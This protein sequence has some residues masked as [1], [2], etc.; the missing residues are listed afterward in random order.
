MNSLAVVPPRFEPVDYDPFQG[1]PLAVVVP[2]TDPQ[3]EIWLADQLGTE[4]SLAF[5]L[6]VSLHLRGP[7]DV[8]ALHAALQDLVDRNDSLRASVGP[9]GETFCVLEHA[10]IA[11]PCLD[12]ASMPAAERE[13]ARVARLEASVRTPFDLA[14]GPLFRAELLRLGDGE[15]LLMLSAHHIACDGWSWWVLVRELG[16]LYGTRTGAAS[17]PPGPPASFADYALAQ[18]DA[19]ADPAN[20][21]DEAYWLARF[22]DQVPVLDLPTD[23][24]RPVRRGTASARVDHVLHDAVLEELRKLGARRGRSLFAT[25]LAGFSGLLSRLTGQRDV[26]VGIPA[27]GQPVAGIETLVGHCVSTL[28]LRFDVD[29]AQSFSD[30]VDHAQA[31]LID[32]LEHQRITFGSLLAKLR[33]ERDPSRVPLV[34][35]LFNLDQ[36]LDQEGQSFPGLELAFR[37][38]PRANETF[39]LFVN[40]VQQ[41]GELHLECQYNSDLFDGATVKRWLQSYEALL[42][43]AVASDATEF[44]RLPVLDRPALE[45]LDALHDTRRPYDRERRMHEYLELQ[46]DRSPGRTAVVCGAVA[47]TYAELDARANR[48]ANLLRQHGVGRGALVGLAVDR[49]VDMLV[50][51]LGVLKSGAGYVPLDPH[52]P[53]ARL[54]YM[55]SDAGLRLLVASREHVARF[56][57]TPGTVLVLEDAM[58]ALDAMPATRPGR[59]GAA[60]RPGDVAY[61]IYTSGSTGRPKGVVVPHRAVSNFLAAML[62]EPGLDEGDRLVAV[63]TLSFD[64]AVLELLLPLSVGACVVLADRA[65]AADGHELAG[66]LSRS[67]ATVM[68]ATPSTWR[69]LLE[70]GWRGGPAFKALCG[71]EALPPDLAARLTTCCGE[72]WNL[73][74][75]TETTVWSTAARIHASPDESPPDVCIGRPIANTIVRILDPRGEPCP[76]GVPGEICIGGDGVTLG[77]LGRP[78]MTAERFVPDRLAGAGDD[79]VLYRTGDRGRWR[80]DGQ[81]EHLGRLDFQVKVR[82]YRIELGEVEASLASHPTVAGTVAT[83]REDV[84][85]DARLVAYVVPASGTAVDVDGLV[86]HLRDR[87]PDYMLPQHVVVLDAL[88]LLPN[89]KVDRGSLPMPS[90]VVAGAAT[91][92]PPASEAERRITELVAAVLGQRDVGPDDDFFAMGG[93]SLLGARLLAR[94]GDAFGI[95]VPLR[96][97]FEA[98][99]AA[100]L[101]QAVARIAEARDAAACPPTPGEIARQPD[102]SRAPLSPMQQRVWVQE[103]LHPGRATFGIASAYRLRGGLDTAALG[104]ALA[105]VVAHQPSLRTALEVEG[106]DP[107]QRVHG[108]VPVALPLEDLSDRPGDEAHAEAMRRI[109]ALSAE[110]IA[111]AAAPLF[112]TRLFRLDPETHVLFFMAHHAIWD[113]V[114]QHL[115]E[116]EMAQAYGARV[117]G[118]AVALPP[119]ERSYVDFV[120]W[121]RG[122]A[123]LPEAREQLAHWL[124]RLP[125]GIEPLQL[126][127]DLPRPLEPSGRGGSE[128]VRID[129]DT[130]AGLRRLGAAVDASL[131]M[132]LLAVYFAWLYRLTGQRDLVVG[133]PVRSHVPATMDG[134]MGFFVN[135]L[136]V[137]VQVDPGA[138]FMALI[139]RV[140]D[141]VLDCFSQ[142]DVALEALVQGLRLRRDPSRTPLYQA[143]FSFQEQQGTAA[144]WATVACEPLDLPQATASNDLAAWCVANDDGLRATLNYNADILLPSS[145][146]AMARRFEAM[147]ARVEARPDAVLGD[148][149]WLSAEDSRA[150]AAWNAT[151]A[152]VQGPASVHGMLAAQF[153]AT[154]HAEAIVLDGK[155]TSYAQLEARSRRIAAALHARGVGA[156]DLVGVCLD[157]H[158]DMVACL[159]GILAAGAGYVPLDPAY[160]ADR[161]R[162]MAEDAGLVMVVGE[163]D[164]ADPLGLPD[165]RL[166]RLDA[167]A[168]WIDGIA[169]DVRL[170]EVGPDDTAYVIY[171]SGSTGKPKGVRIPHGAVANFLAS[172]RRRPGILPSDRLLA[173]TTTSFDIAVLEI[174]L[175]LA[176]GACVVLASRED[177]FD[178]VALASLLERSGA[179]MMQGTPSVWRLLLDSGWRG[180]AGFKALCG[181]EPLAPDLA[182]GLL[183]GGVE[184]W[185]MYGP[186]ETTVW[187]TCAR[188]HPGPVGAPPD[189]HVGTPIDNTTVW[190]LDARGQVCPPGVPGEIHIGGAGVAVGYLARPDLTAERFVDDRF[191]TAGDRAPSRL[192]PRLYRTGDRGRLRHDGN[193]QHEGRLDFQLKLRGHRIEPGEVESCLVACDDVAQALVVVREMA[194][195]DLRLVAY[196]VGVPGAAVDP[197]VLRTR[198][199]DAL[200]AYMV[201]QHVVVLD[202][203][204]ILPNGKIDRNALPAPAVSMEAAAP[205][206]DAVGP[207]ADPRVRYLA[208]VWS[209][210]LGVPAGPG[211]NF[212]ELGGHSMLAVQMANRVQRDTGVRIRLIRLAAGTLAQFA[213]ELPMGGSTEVARPGMG[214]RVTDG[215]RRLFGLTA[216][217]GR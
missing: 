38:N 55:A 48:F 107:I 29:P 72:L 74:G 206:Q 122:Q 147:L 157:R 81:L 80:P 67:G 192:P 68:Q 159:V 56:D 108:D 105:D 43:A 211:D 3:R 46:C 106:D 156:G 138:S 104:A 1:G 86:G 30:L 168:G 21:E 2:T 139:V 17:A 50:A 115:F 114:S 39:E 51:L 184:L 172:M 130:L 45:E 91:P 148:L 137:H 49:D 217:S 34:A 99:T 110:P 53:A 27:A 193:L 152:P 144:R 89:G 31:T 84:P 196:V 203:F 79:A 127:E 100:R 73:Y 10:D 112:R 205:L 23:R 87:L 167:D 150:L 26:V 8:P 52:F 13:A 70:A 207:A 143:V 199:R 131:F 135:L 41:G 116:L 204:P 140:R 183:A 96:T 20:A 44:G 133:V 160:P 145:A 171:T 210:L 177:V 95:R 24:P 209:E 60:A 5:N 69:L 174:F 154:P 58:Q 11:V 188:I 57:P 162:F 4:A 134:V 9:D 66:L 42:R 195:G 54:A 97:L 14:R 182:R 90:G 158:P 28:P 103:Q 128:S 181:G 47:L 37:S 85:G 164:L 175:P 155:A 109:E 98:P 176:N 214:R 6:S 161:L 113:G 36:A 77:Y 170:P 165:D 208:Q 19:K 71:G 169:P 61:V 12:L 94:V 118:R 194:P 186:T 166:L 76:R 40:A 117:G 88:P 163:G 141:A 185:N 178:G 16:A 179:T 92:R 187:S 93:H 120:H 15:H 124:R 18:A 132:T 129:G 62:H 25:L 180:H 151:G 198:L 22:R 173:V 75:P 212:F 191:A 65:T 189:V 121:Q 35:V 78:D 201:P 119:L 101:A 213:D 149:D 216:G 59:D 82:G 202:A 7:L 153:A 136:P 111:L 142:P 64:I 63:T 215:L 102:Q 32:A 83:V 190:I 146:S 125:A 200:P 123:V 197:A 126:P 33:V